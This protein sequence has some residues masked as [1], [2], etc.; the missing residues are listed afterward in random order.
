MYWVEVATTVGAVVAFVAA[1][2]YA[3]YRSRLPRPLRELNRLLDDGRYEEARSAKVPSGRDRA[4][5]LCGQAMASLACGDFATTERL[6]DEAG[7]TPDA[8]PETLTLARWLLASC[9]A[10]VGR[11]PDAIAIL[12]DVPDEG[13]PRILR[14][15]IAVEC[16]EDD[17]AEELLEQRELADLHEALRLDALGALRARQGAYAESDGLLAEA[18]RLLRSD[19][20][21]SHLDIASALARRAEVAVELGHPDAA[22]AYLGVAVDTIDGWPQHRPGTA[23]VHGTAARVLARRGDADGALAHLERVRAAV[24]VMHSP[25]LRADLE[26]TA[27]EVAA[28]RTDH[29]AART[30]LERAIALHEELG[31]R[32]ATDR[33]RRRLADLA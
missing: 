2:A 26:A 4:P 7:R 14:A 21:S 24:A 9:R 11:Y 30:H 23:V 12:A 22:D 10:Q 16:G 28:A 32:P 15:R 18:V 17:L 3:G 8:T 20:P 13:L 25:P 19:S 31:E 33:L 27:A 6:L 1:V 29:Q 5:F